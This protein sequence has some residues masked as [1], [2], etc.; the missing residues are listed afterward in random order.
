LPGGASEAFKRF[1]SRLVVNEASLLNVELVGCADCFGSET[2]LSVVLL[3]QLQI[4]QQDQ[5]SDLY[6]ANQLFGLLI[7]GFA[8]RRD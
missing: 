5:V 8:V 6:L 4:T 7:V 2:K 1:F 3:V